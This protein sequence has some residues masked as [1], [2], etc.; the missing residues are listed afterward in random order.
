M[1]WTGEMEIMV[2]MPSEGVWLFSRRRG[3]SKWT[4]IEALE[5]YKKIW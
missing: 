4:W 2:N 3:K 5:T 1:V